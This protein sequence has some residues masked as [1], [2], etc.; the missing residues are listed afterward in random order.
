MVIK[1]LS[2]LT[3]IT[4]TTKN[5]KTPKTEEAP[6]EPKTKLQMNAQVDRNVDFNLKKDDLM[7]L[8]VE[9][10]KENME[11]EISRLTM[12]IQELELKFNTAKEGFEKV[13]ISDLKNAFIDKARAIV[14]HLPEPEKGLVVNLSTTFLHETCSVA[15]VSALKNTFGEK[16][17]GLMK[18]NKQENIPLT[19]YTRA[20]FEIIFDFSKDVYVDSSLKLFLPVIQSS[21]SYRDNYRTAT[22][23]VGVFDL[24]LEEQ[25]KLPEFIKMK[26]AAQSLLQ[27][28]KE[29]AEFTA[30]YALLC[31]NKERSKAA[32]IKQ[33][34]GQDA[35]GQVLLENL[36]KA[37][38]SFKLL[39]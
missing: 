34:L 35:N 14:A 8:I 18:I 1:L 25:K 12:Q 10:R 4:M 37:S 30:D 3:S 13:M 9:G 28:K 39:S 6:A 38:K 16:I 21:S 32:M 23:T 22:V 29:V 26:E 36:T 17:G 15:E 31:A 33:I 5:T 20:E 24:N 11:E 7:T 27:V 2:H 19:I